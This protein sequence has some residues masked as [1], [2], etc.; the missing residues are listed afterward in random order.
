MIEFIIEVV[1]EF[2]GEFL[3]QLTFEVLARL[4]LRALRGAAGAKPSTLVAV[5]GYLALGV[6]S[7]ALSFLF[8]PRLMIHSTQG[9]WLNLILTPLLVGGV[10]SASA[11]ML[12]RRG[13][14]SLRFDRF[15]Y[16]TLFAFAMALTR[17]YLSRT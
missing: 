4:G 2:L 1:L 15:A 3:L 5:A 10:M 7:G 14:P 11:S 13:G 16:A 6:V 8:F 17:L 12:M 9:Q